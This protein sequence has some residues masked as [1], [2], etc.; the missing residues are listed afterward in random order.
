VLP[1]IEASRDAGAP[2]VEEVVVKVAERNPQKLRQIGLNYDIANAKGISEPTEEQKKKQEQKKKDA[3]EKK[4]KRK[5]KKNSRSG[6]GRRKLTTTPGRGIGHARSERRPKKRTASLNRRMTKQ[7]MSHS[8]LP[9][10]SWRSRL[11]HQ[12]LPP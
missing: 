1:K 6:R 11:T 4:K 2:S 10:Q 12:N 8:L 3:A 5:K 7:R 9:I